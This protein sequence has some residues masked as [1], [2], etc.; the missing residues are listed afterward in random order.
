MVRTATIWHLDELCLFFAESFCGFGL[1]CARYTRKKKKKVNRG[2]SELVVPRQELL[3]IPAALNLLMAAGNSRGSGLLKSCEVIAVIVVLMIE[4]PKSAAL[5]MAA[6]CLC[7]GAAELLRWI[8]VWRMASAL[9]LC[10]G[11][12]KV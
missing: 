8:R 1:I 3:S 4:S 6:C 7:R 11:M 2:V 9:S 10:K 12:M 5:A